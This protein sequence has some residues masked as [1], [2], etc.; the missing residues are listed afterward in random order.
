M[1][2]VKDI[3]QGKDSLDDS[4]KLFGTHDIVLLMSQKDEIKVYKYSV[5][6]LGH[7]VNSQ[8]A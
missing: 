7:L 5:G 2:Q 4:L 3:V 8:F 6:D 1:L